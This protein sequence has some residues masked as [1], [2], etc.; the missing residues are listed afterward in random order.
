MLAPYQNWFDLNAV[1]LPVHVCL[2]QEKLQQHKA[3]YYFSV[4]PFPVSLRQH[5]NKIIMQ[6]K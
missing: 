1:S 3:Y 5:E 4:P 2:L 6:H